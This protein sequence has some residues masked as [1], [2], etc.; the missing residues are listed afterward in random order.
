MKN[1]DRKHWLFSL[2]NIAAIIYCTML[3]YA[4]ACLLKKPAYNWDMLPYMGV[5]LSYD[6][7]DI[8]VI[9]NEVYATAKKEVPAVYYNR[10]VDPL[11]AYRNRVAQNP[12]VFYSQFP[13]YMVKPLYTRLAWCFYKAGIVLPMATVLPSVVAYVLI[14][15]LLFTWL[16]IYRN[17]WWACIGSM[18]IMLS[19]PLI[20]VAGLSSPDAISGLLVFASVFFLTEKKSLTGAII[21][22]LLSIFARL[23]N[24][25]PAL[26]F[27]AIIFFVGKWDNKLSALTFSLLISLLCLA[28]FAVSTGV[29]SFGWSLLYYPAFAKQLNASYSNNSNFDFAAYLSLA[30]SQLTTGLY[31]SFI[32]IF[33]FLVLLLVWNSTGYKFSQLT[34]EQ[35][36]AVVFLLIIVIRFILQPL[37]ADRI[38]IPYYLSVFVFLVKK[39]SLIINRL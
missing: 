2:T 11:N 31:F 5:V 30:K 24:I 36:L 26:F 32:S 16:K 35:T 20:T 9:H 38:Y 13:F 15:I 17:A 1:V 39:N 7:T 10:M 4:T 29:R 33:F 25:L 23:D 8:K 27:L 22:L 18:L 12:D 37:V 14:G 34:L 19:P 21:C 28:F 3:L 6:Q